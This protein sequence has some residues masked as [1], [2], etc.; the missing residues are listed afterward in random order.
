[1]PIRVSRDASGTSAAPAPP[2]D[3]F[4]V[5][6]LAKSSL[7][8]R[9]A[10]SIFCG[11]RHEVVL[12][13]LLELLPMYCSTSADVVHCG[14]S[15]CQVPRTQLVTSTVSLVLSGH[16]NSTSVSCCTTWPTRKVTY[17]PLWP[18]A[19]NRHFFGVHRLRADVS[20]VPNVHRSRTIML[21]DSWYP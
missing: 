5:D 9:S 3:A 12:L 17:C 13:L 10:F 20:Q 11:E 19:G 2:P 8:Y 15:G 4:V 18:K 16:R 6:G 1:M 14:D 21:V 7:K